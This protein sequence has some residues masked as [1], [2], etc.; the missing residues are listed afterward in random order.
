V[1]RKERKVVVEHP[2]KME[3][4]GQCLGFQLHEDSKNL[5]VLPIYFLIA[6]EVHFKTFKRKIA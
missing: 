6:T 3:K 5:Q 2:N 4:D 1:G